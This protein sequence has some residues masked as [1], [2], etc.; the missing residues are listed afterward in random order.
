[1]NATRNL[2]I[3]LSLLISTLA[4]AAKGGNFRRSEVIA[5]AHANPATARVVSVKAARHHVLGGGNG[6]DSSFMLVEHGNGNVT[7]VRAPHNRAQKPHILSTATMKAMG[8]LTQARAKELAQR[9][10]SKFGSAGRV[11][12]K[13]EGMDRS[14]GSYKFKQLSPRSVLVKEGRR[15]YRASDISRTVPLTGNPGETASAGT[16]K[17]LP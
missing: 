11:R 15:T 12:V 9:N 4:L 5:A 17:L 1:M 16:W 6:R 14:G 10:G 13:N 8:M 2:I 3:G 7:P